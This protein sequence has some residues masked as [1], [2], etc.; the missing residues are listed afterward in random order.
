MFTSIG[1]LVLEVR[2]DEFFNRPAVRESPKV[3]MALSSLGD[4]SKNE[5]SKQIR[6]YHSNDSHNDRLWLAVPRNR[7]VKPGCGVKSRI[8]RY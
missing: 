3:V 6:T 1:T 8:Q 2:L 5:E 4:P 7:T